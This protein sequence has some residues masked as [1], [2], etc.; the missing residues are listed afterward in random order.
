MSTLFKSNA[1]ANS[2][3][4]LL[5]LSAIL[6]EVLAE[7]PEILTL[8]SD[9]VVLALFLYIHVAVHAKLVSTSV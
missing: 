2:D 3:E 9:P 8:P 4:E 5:Q 1:V 6:H 7:C